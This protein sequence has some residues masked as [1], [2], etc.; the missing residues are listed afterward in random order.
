M[1]SEEYTVIAQSLKARALAYRVSLDARLRKMAKQ[2]H[3]NDGDYMY[4]H[5]HNAWVGHETHPWKN[6]DYAI[7]YQMRQA[8]AHM[9]DADRIVR[10]YLDKLW[11]REVYPSI[12]G[13]QYFR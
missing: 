1:T 8:E 7:L 2:A 9:W 4:L 5:M 13:E 10:T 3:I 11:K 6:V 12:T